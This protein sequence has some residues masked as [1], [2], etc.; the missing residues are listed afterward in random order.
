MNSS[1]EYHVEVV[2][3]PTRLEAN[4]Y[5]A[6]IFEIVAVQAMM[7]GY[8]VTIFYPRGALEVRRR[9]LSRVGF[10]RPLRRCRQSSRTR[11]PP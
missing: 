10:L 9:A 2:A 4:D 6:G 7:N 5:L 3:I 11:S 8:A 1:R